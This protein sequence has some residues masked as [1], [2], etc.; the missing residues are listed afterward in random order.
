[1]ATTTPKPAP[2]AGPIER[3]FEVSLF[4][5]VVTGF[6][7]LVSTGRLD[8]LSL[9][10]VSIALVLRGGMLLRNRSAVIPERWDTVLTLTYVLFYVVDYFLISDSFVTASVHLVLFSL[11]VKLFSLRRT[12]DFLYLALLSF[13]E[14][15]A[16]AILTVDTLFLA[17][18][19]VFLLLGITTFV[20]FEMKRSAGADLHRA[21]APR[22]PDRVMRALT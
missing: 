6:L 9:A 18:F 11:V 5:L 15:L 4:L 3:Y 14:V 16:A 20:S 22:V 1:M 12:R 8:P 7:T 2:A 21:T 17:S 10:M 13:L 19:S